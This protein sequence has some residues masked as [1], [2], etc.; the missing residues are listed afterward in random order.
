MDTITDDHR[1]N[2]HA[3]L[4]IIGAGYAGLTLANCLQVQAASRRRHE[5]HI[6]IIDRLHPPD[7][8]RYIHGSIQ[9]PYV[10]ELLAKIMALD[11]E[12]LDPTRAQ[13]LLDN[14]QQSM[15]RAPE[16]ELLSLLRENVPVN[17]R[18]E[19]S[20]IV[21]RNGLL[22]AHVHLRKSDDSNWDKLM[23]PYDWIIVADGALSC[24]RS[25]NIPTNRLL[26]IGDAQGQPWWD[27]GRTRL[28]RGADIAM[29]HGDQVASLL[30]EWTENRHIHP[31][32]LN[33]FRPHIRWW[34]V[35]LLRG[36]FLLLLPLSL[37][38]WV[39]RSS[40]SVVNVQHR[41]PPVNSLPTINKENE[42]I[43]NA[44]RSTTVR[45]VSVKPKT[46]FGFSYLALILVVTLNS[47][48][49]WFLSLYPI[50][51]WHHPQR[52][53]IPDNLISE[54]ATP[55]ILARLD[56]ETSLSSTPIISQKNNLPNWIS[57]YLEWHIQTR[58]QLNESN[59]K[60][61]KYLVSRCYYNDPQCGGLVDRLRALPFLVQVAA[62]TGR[63]LL[64][65]WERPYDLS[66][67]LE[68]VTIDWSLPPFV[69]VPRHLFAFTR[70]TD[71]PYIQKMEE[72]VVSMRLQAYKEA[73][74]FFDRYKVKSND[75]VTMEV[76]PPLWKLF[77]RPTPPIQQ[78]IESIYK[79]HGLSP[80]KYVAVHLRILYDKDGTSDEHLLQSVSNALACTTR[81]PGFSSSTPIVVTSDSQEAVQLAAQ[82][83][84]DH[85]IHESNY[86][87]PTLHLDRGSQFL[88]RPLSG[89]TSRESVVAYYPTFVDFYL[90]MGAKCVAFDR[91]GF[92]RLASILAYSNCSFNHQH[93]QC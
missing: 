44:I 11:S 54:Y 31:A 76:L 56:N 63:L 70:V 2:G 53:I 18:Y 5:F 25:L 47:F 23:G 16:Q 75:A 13:M 58:Q 92:G 90:L 66:E 34:Q 4:L 48:S 36:L 61:Y 77:F 7:P 71:V 65:H 32:A 19:A 91:G 78:Q 21:L 83:A 74:K 33:K 68:P 40:R 88:E 45:P 85:V 93:H 17:Y 52:R 67:F 28:Q 41:S 43:Q 14:L 20:R 87:G 10:K 30:L 64:F 24:F 37:A 46:F 82:L 38:F 81:F 39:T 55:S 22:Y 51:E 79:Q 29:R 6:D 60:N 27:F 50:G 15:F 89:T 9:S 3:R 26:V 12:Y 86:S 49:L 72:T 62:M 59:W 69:K 57:S 8:E 80:S 1:H 73:Q 42:K 35:V 84:P